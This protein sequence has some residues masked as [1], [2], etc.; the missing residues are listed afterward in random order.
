MAEIKAKLGVDGEAGFKKAINEAAGS[1]K[2]LKSALELAKSEYQ[3]TGDKAEYLKSKSET[4][5]AEIEAQKGVIEAI[6]GA[7]DNAKSKYGESSTKVQNWKIKLNSAKTALNN[8]Q[9]ELQSTETDLGNVGTAMDNATTDTGELSEALDGLNKK[10]DL[11]ALKSGL[12]TVSRTLE[13]AARF[14]AKVGKALWGGT[15]EASDWA[16]ELSTMSQVYGIDTQT[17]QQWQY[18]SK[19]IDTDVDVI[20]KARQKMVKGLTSTSAEVKKAWNALGVSTTDADGE[21]KNATDLM[22]EA[23]DAL[24]Q[25]ENETERDNLAMTLFGK[26]AAEL[27]P[28]IKAG[29]DAW[30]ALMKEGQRNGSVVSKQDVERLAEFNDQWQRMDS[31]VSGMKTTFFAA[32]APAMTTIA[33]ALADASGK[34]REFLESAEG[35]EAIGKLGDSV[36]NFV[37]S[38]IEKLPDLLPA[39]TGL[40]DALTGLLGFVAE[41]SEEIAAVLGSLYVGSKVGSGVTGLAQVWT[42]LKGLFGLGGGAAGAG[43]AGGGASA[44][45]AGAAGGGALSGALTVAAPYVMFGAAVTMMAQQV[46]VHGTNAF[47][48]AFSGK[49]NVAQAQAALAASGANDDFSQKASL[50]AGLYMA[51]T[52]IQEDPGEGLPAMREFLAGLDQGGINTLKELLPN[53]PMWNEML[54]ASLPETAEGIAAWLQNVDDVNLI[55]DALQLLPEIAAMFAEGGQFAE[56]GKT[57]GENLGQGMQ[58]GAEGASDLSGAGANAGST[59]VESASGY[60]PQAYS[61]GAGLGEAFANGLKDVLGIASPSKVMMAFGAFTARGFAEGIESG[62]GEVENAVWAMTEATTGPVSAPRGGGQAGVADMIANALRGVK[63]Q[64]DGVTAGALLTP[65]VSEILGAQA[66]SWRYDDQ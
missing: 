64:I 39:L 65:T 57:A 33:D 37:T 58:E 25:I 14:A 60:I 19:L 13:N 28:L 46:D 4:L 66:D 12:D 27:N 22:W 61:A 11:S 24:G 29:R 8:M 18:A 26:S 49:E 40:V 63:V 45:G 5:K 36:A 34:L 7:L 16:D 3:L 51:M 1:V 47:N 10:G 35:Q 6:Q 2:E 50:M 30:E 62:I 56:A 54:N 55:E 31:I 52:G 32:L 9:T 21:F 42:G 41:H 48:S 59:F 53:L 43:A 38:L 44:A 17:L 20:L 23:L 15:V